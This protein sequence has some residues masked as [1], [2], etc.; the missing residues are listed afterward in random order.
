MRM[1]TA[2]NGVHV[3]TTPPADELVDRA[4]LGDSDARN[5][6]AQRHY[7]AVWSLARK[8]TREDNAA[9]DV[10]QE[11]FLRAFAHLEQWD[12][13]HRFASWLYKIATNYVR[14]LHRRRRQPWSVEEAVQPSG[15]VLLE[16]SESIEQ[17][18]KAL[19]TLPPETRAAMVLHLQEELTIPE[20]AF[21]LELSENAV[22]NKIYRGLQ[23]LRSLVVEV[24]P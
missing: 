11:T 7:A 21:V 12:G 10:A 13:R 20:I 1:L 6:L 5:R 16:R 3:M 8:L 19:D 23:K 17:V 9:H 14:D 22:R 4:R 2:S 15:D 24:H 18:R